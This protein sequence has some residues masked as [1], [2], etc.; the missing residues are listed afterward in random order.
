MKKYSNL[1]KKTLVVFMMIVLIFAQYA[2]FGNVSIYGLDKELKFSYSGTAQKVFINQRYDF[3]TTYRE[4]KLG[5]YVSYCV[6]YGRKLPSGTLVYKRELS[7][8]ALSVLIA[9]Y[10]NRTNSQIGASSN[11]EAY[12]ATQL[13]FWTVINSTGD[14]K[15]NGLQFDYNDLKPLAGNETLLKNTISTAK[16]IVAYAKANPYNS[17]FSMNI[18]KSSASVKNLYGDILAGPY[19]ITS[20]GFGKNKAKLTLSNKTIAKIVDVDGNALS[21]VSA[22]QEFYVS[23]PNV[24]KS[25]EISL[26][27]TITGNE[28]VGAVY[29]QTISGIQDYATA[30]K[31]PISIE[32]NIDISWTVEDP[33]K[34]K[35]LKT[36]Q[37]GVGISGVEFKLVNSSN[38]TIAEG[39]TN[40]NGVIEFTNLEAGSYRIIETAVPSS[41]IKLDSTPISVTVKAGQT[42]EK[43]IVNNRIE[44]KGSL[45]IIKVDQY[46]NRIANVRF[47]LK[48]ENGSLI[49]IRPTNSNGE[50]Q[51]TELSPGKYKL[52]EVSVPDSS[53]IYDDTVMDIEIVGGQ[54]TVKTIINTKKTTPNR[55]PPAYGSLR[56]IKVDQN[57]NKIQGVTFELR[58][59]NGAVISTDMTDSQGIIDYTKLAPGTYSI[60]ETAVPS[61]DYVFNT[62]PISINISANNQTVKTIVNEK[63]KKVDPIKGSLK[64]EKIDEN[65]N[66][67]SNVKFN[68]LNSTKNVIATLTTDSNGYATISGLAEG[69][70]YYREISAP[71]N[72]VIDNTEYLVRITT[73]NKDIVK[74]IVNN[75]VKGSLQIEKID[76][77]GKAV[78]NVTFEILDSS[79]TKVVSTVT[80]NSNGIAK[81]NNLLKGVYY[82]RETSVPDYVIKNTDLVGFEIKNNNEVITKQVVNKLVKSTFQI[83][84]VDE[85]GKAIPN[86]TFEILDSSR[87]VIGKVTT[88]QN[89]I[90]K[91]SNLNKGN[92]YYKEINVPSDYAIDI[93]EYPFEIQRNN[94]IVTK[95]VI[96]QFIK[97]SLKIIKVDEN[98]NPISNVKFDIIDTKGN[99]IDSIVTNNDGIAIKD[100][101]IKGTYYYK[102][103]SAPDNVLI[104]NNK[105]EFKITQNGQIV[106]KTIENK[107]IR[108]NL[109]IIKLNEEQKPI[110][111]VEFEIL[112]SSKKVI[113][114]IITDK[115]G[116]ANF[117]NLLKGTYYYR[118]I[119][120]PEEYAIDNELHEFKIQNHEE[121]LEI[122]VINNYK[123]A[124]LQ[125]IKLDKTT[126]KPIKDV[127]FKIFNKRG[128]EVEIITTDEQGI[129][130]TDLLK[131]G[132]YTYKE[133][134]APS[135][136]VMDPLTHEFSI[137]ENGADIQE[138]VYNRVKEALPITGA[139]LNT[140]FAIIL[141]V[142]GTCIIGYMV[143]VH[144]KR[145][146]KYKKSQDE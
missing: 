141:I 126:Q 93:N 34:I 105:Y 80:T 128:E 86:V 103:A 123:K 137:N 120:A 51:Y 40:S 46:N 91:I 113:S 94:Q 139:L 90:A 124:K 79:K 1:L 85:N 18:N 8:L 142:A 20:T 97:G 115:N 100:K 75:F 70:Y 62:S 134:Y 76:E 13:A 38:K 49:S 4:G 125:I 136:Y 129:A 45:K 47:E 67:V 106:S 74:R 132:T 39:K 110:E 55:V 14:S 63:I 99:I 73:S 96:N 50:I 52:K 127:I 27:A 65:G 83:Q 68:I 35:V 16:K 53:Y 143:F 11:K 37:N 43:K 2:Y 7:N 138:I 88:D 60:V 82:F 28:Y 121:T 78:P 89:G 107:L 56:I 23:I 44:K 117:D 101:L 21:Q 112:D 102:E 64:L 22:G 9:G 109:N 130:H 92:Y 69:T 32:K 133:V 41:D 111:N 3:E 30:V 87:N 108:G 140:D 131:Y 114:K 24:K 19:K 71:S 36:D 6:D 25:G 48:R 5:D 29:G 84:K 54:E 118:E 98:K 31:K 15:Q 116:K 119:N 77:E 12:L 17:K 26:T 135:D 146:N 58:N 145:K 59:S 33:A 57:G 10:P 144:I 104:D 66:P 122:K 81:V 95:K 42:V 61:S 72:L